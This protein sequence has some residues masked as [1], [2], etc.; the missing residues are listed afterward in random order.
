MV[1]HR[2]PLV[3][4]LLPVYNA[5]LTLDEALHSL[6]RQ[7]MGNFEVIAVDDGSTDSSVNILFDWKQK[8]K[9]FHIITRE[10]KGIVPSLNAG[11]EAC[12][13]EF[14]A[15]M[16]ADDVCHPERLERQ[17]NYLEQNPDTALVGCRIRVIPEVHMGDGFQIYI[18][19]QNSLLTNED[20]RREMFIESPFSHPSVMFRKGSVLKA[21][22]YIEQGLPEDYDLWLRLYILNM[23]LAKLPEVLLDWRDSPSRLTRTDSRYSLENFLRLKAHYLARGPLTGRKSVFVWGAGMMGRRLSKHL[24]HEGAPLVAFIDVDARKIGRTR[25]GYPILSPEALG[26]AWDG[27]DKPVLLAAVG[28]RGARP[29]IR[30]HLL[31]KNFKEGEDWWFV[32]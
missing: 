6:A 15:R 4:V 21:G 16:D 24:L 13:S 17:V 32:A 27:A 26:G 3:S 14:I 29:L 11:L 2:K 31:G 8:D 30:Q 23:K 20:I 7:T 19:W 12:R 1:D 25:R 18:Q 22:G 10:H 5:A 28:A 9:R